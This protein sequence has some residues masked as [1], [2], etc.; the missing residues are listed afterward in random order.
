MAKKIVFKTEIN[1]EVPPA[2]PEALFRDLKGR[3][4]EVKHL[5]AHQADILRAYHERHLKTRDVALELPTGAGKTLVGLLVAEFRRRYF[6]D[7][8]AYL[9]PTRQLAKQ[10][11]AQAAKYGI[12]AH[13]FVGKQRDYPADKFSEY[14]MG[15]AV[16]ITTYNGVFNT[17]PRIN[18][19]QA[20]ILDDAH[21]SETY[22]AGMWSVEVRRDEKPDLY[23]AILRL[24]A[25]ALP[26]PFVADVMGGEDSPDRQ[27][28][29]E[30]V[31]GAD[32]RQRSQALL[33]LFAAGLSEGEPA[34]YA[35]SMLRDH[36]PA[37]SMFACRE[38]V[39]IRPMVPPTMRHMPFSQASQRVYMSATLGS[40][41]ELERITGVKPIERIPAPPG[42]D[43]QGIGRRLF[44]APH[45]S[46]GDGNALVVFVEAM[47]EIGR[48]LSLV[49]NQY[50]LS[51]LSGI[52]SKMGLTVLGASDI[53]DST[54]AF[55]GASSVALVLSRYDGLDLPDEA[56]RLLVLWGLPA[57]TNLQER[58]LLSR[59]A[60]SS[61]LRDRILTRFT[62]GVGRCT[63][64]DND[65][66]VVL[67]GDRALVDF[68]V[69]RENRTI[70]HP[71]LQ[72]ELDFGIE[73]SKD[74]EPADYK[75]LWE[76]FLRQGEDWSAAEKTIIATRE[77][78]SRRADPS[79]ERLR[80]VVGN[81]LD[82]LYALWAGDYERALEKA[83]AVSDALGGDETKGYRGWWYYLAGDA[84]LLLRQE[85]K[86]EALGEVAKDCLKRAATCCPAISWFARLS[87]L[88]DIELATE[89]VDEHTSMAVEAIRGKLAEWG[90]VGRTF[91]DQMAMAMADVNSD[92]HTKF[93]RG[94]KAVGL[95]LG[96]DAL[97]PATDAAP[98]GVW[99]L[100][101]TLHIVHEAKTEHTPGDPIGVNDVRQAQSHADW[102]LANLPCEKEATVI[103]VMETPRKVVAKD[104]L[105]HAKS[106]CRVDPAIIR[107]LAEEAIGVLRSVRSVAG[108]I[109]DEALLEELMKK[110]REA[111]LRP[112]DVV[113]R[114]TQQKVSAMPQR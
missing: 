56:C 112:S 109:G 102:V 12:T 74:K 11:G 27:R 103:C 58:F 52:L 14:E 24:F 26:A 84:A 110:L 65:Y 16:A 67:L 82:Y 34:A 45:I 96:F 54:A 31:S 78:K 35:W 43:N 4:P 100:G 9:C 38:S 107:S 93:H 94:L 63:R 98:D 40:G 90:L 53:E 61:L 73:N 36:L 71:E 105:P 5:W 10:A 48:S 13:V 22:I 83:K 108:D 39:L 19:A 25:D 86:R 89:G 51:Y 30:L 42:W 32:F 91:E 97:A 68:I 79:T 66:A 72:A 33:D 6:H 29:V 75:E 59:L 88:A 104:A 3:A 60:A 85:S 57:G 28:I 41:G 69:K 8:V 114:L 70:L 77:K 1:G 95:M 7:R 21:S 50:A 17:N 87:R 18:D 46:L 47:K 76:A 20:I 106:L 2:D 44:L 99:S 49:P 37:C 15:N 81:E 101:D 64:S 55:T 111:R 80:Q 62:Q 92:K 23:K 113:Q